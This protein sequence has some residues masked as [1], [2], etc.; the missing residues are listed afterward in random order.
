MFG[1]FNTNNVL[2]CANK[3]I[4]S[5]DQCWCGAGTCKNHHLMK[6]EEGSTRESVFTLTH[7]FTVCKRTDLQTALN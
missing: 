6:N 4:I 1:V 2:G 7:I 5:V 3:E